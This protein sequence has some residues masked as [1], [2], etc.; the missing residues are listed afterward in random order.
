MRLLL[1]TIIILFIF[2]ISITANADV[3][4]NILT[5]DMAIKIAIA[6]NSLIKEAIERQKVATQE[7]KSARAELLPK[8]SALYSYTRLKETPYAVFGSSRV[9]ISDRDNFHWDIT[10]TQ[11]IFTGFALSTKRKIAEL[12]VKMREIEKEQAILDVIKNVKTAYFNILLAEKFLMVAQEAVRQLEAHVKDAESFYREGLI[13]YNDLLK[14]KVALANALQ[15]KVRAESSLE[16]AVSSFNTLLGFDINCKTRVK[17]ILKPVP[18]SQ[19]LDKLIEIALNERPELKTLRLALKNA[20]YAIKLAR[21]SYYP[22]IVLVGSYEQNGDDPLATNNDFRN[23][24]NASITLQARVTLFDWGKTRAEVKRYYHEKMSLTEKIKG[25]EDSIKL[26]V[27][28]AFLN[29]RVASQNIQTARESLSQ[30]KENFRITDL[31]Y[32]NQ[33]A[34]S[35][36]VIDART[37]LTEAEINYYKAI[38]SYSISIAEL[39]RATG[40]YS[41]ETSTLLEELK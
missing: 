17:D 37:S 29:L 23:A 12:D 25:I 3:Q 34:T 24:H 36:E 6:N 15:E 19:E 32:K 31:Q 13:A 20:D 7:Y 9:T 18:L 10:V 33:I 28:N 1:T 40:M 4:N 41:L 5:L 39:E 26:E 8:L 30:A 16:M 38:Y 22:E 35:T 14:S 27:K 2:L 11:P 21:S